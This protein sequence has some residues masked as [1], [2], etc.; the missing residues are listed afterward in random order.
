MNV[1]IL[2]IIFNRP[3][4]TKRVFES[5]RQ[6]KPTK[7]FI[8]ADGPRNTRIGEEKLC[9]DTRKI[10]EKIDWSCDVYRNYSEKNLGCYTSVP[11][12]ISWFFENVNNGIILEDDCLPNQSFFSYCESLLDKYKNGENIMLISGDN[13]QNYQ[14]EP[15][16][17]YYFSKYANIWGWASWKRA[18]K[19]FINEFTTIDDS[20]MK[21]K[22]KLAFST[23]E[24][25]DYWLNFY[26]KIK[27]GK[28]D[29]WDAKWFLS[30][31]YN[32]GICLTPT[33]NLIENIGFGNDATNTKNGEGS[34]LQIKSKIL[35]DIRHPEKKDIDFYS[36][37]YLFTKVYRISIF[38]KIY[39]KFFK[40]L[41]I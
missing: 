6:A 12:A 29:N 30:I 18:W 7:L 5:I 37:Q 8:A 21:E 15:T 17:S 40:I 38:K 25:R 28:F 4:T 27:K 22:I 11:R 32:D 41:K 33:I 31:I 35:S 26:K 16:D 14:T 13:F 39:L 2:L 3:E 36:D 23:N 9:S 10:V 24:E 1:P 19:S 20:K 34:N